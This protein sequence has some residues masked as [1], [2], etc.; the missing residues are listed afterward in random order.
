MNDQIRLEKG[1][2]SPAFTLTNDKGEQVS[3]SDFAGKRVI[4]YFY[5]RANTPGCTTE[6]CDF[7]EKLEDFN[8]AS[9][10]VL[11]IS[12]DPTD[13]LAD[14]RA[15]HDLGIELLGD[16][17]KDTLIAYGAFGEKK[18][19]GKVTEGVIRSTFLVN[20]AE[21]GTGT[22]EEAKYNVRA[23]GHVDRILRDW[24]I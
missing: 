3:L 6:A 13:K 12:P 5:P 19:Y 14:F 24:D 7:T 18:M 10:T 11:G 21:D 22:I 8:N 20:V 16:E 9:V 23:S 1:D 15:K 4:V 17:S 2:T